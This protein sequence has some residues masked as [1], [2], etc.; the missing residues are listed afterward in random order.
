[1]GGSTCIITVL[2]LLVVFLQTACLGNPMDRGA[3]RA[4]DLGV[5]ESDTT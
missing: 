4:T 5:A 2:L 3:W 1:M